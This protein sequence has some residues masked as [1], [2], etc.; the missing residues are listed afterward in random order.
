MINVTAIDV[1]PVYDNFDGET[2]FKHDLHNASLM[3][4][5]NIVEMTSSH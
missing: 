4:F 2:N 3:D 5:S 1:V